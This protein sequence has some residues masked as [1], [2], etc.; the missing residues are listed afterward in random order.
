LASSVNVPVV[1]VM[2]LSARPIMA[3]LKSR[4]CEGVTALL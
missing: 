1:I 3:P 4:T 2:P